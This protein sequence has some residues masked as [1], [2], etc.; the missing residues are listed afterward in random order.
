MVESEEE[1]R[2]FTLEE[3]LNELQRSYILLTKGS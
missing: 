2:R 1:L 3:D